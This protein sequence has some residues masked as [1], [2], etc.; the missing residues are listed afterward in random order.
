MKIRFNVTGT[1]RKELVKVISDASG[2]KAKYMGM[3]SAAYEIGDF[4][5]LMD[6]TL[7]IENGED[8][9]GVLDAVLA[10]GFSPEPEETAD[11]AP[12]D[13]EMVNTVQKK[14]QELTVE[15][16]F[17]MVNVGNLMKLLGAKGAL[18][19]KA[20]G[21]ESINIEMKEDRVAFPW[22]F[23]TD[24]DH[25]AAYTRFI[26]ALC[27]MSRESKR[28]TAKEKEV[29]NEKYAFRCLLLRLGFI[30]KDYKS[31]RKILLEKLTGSSA[32]RN[33]GTEHEI[34]E[35]RDSGTN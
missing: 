8:T 17:D 20:L 27:R 29:D 22:F 13:A 24:A 23:G 21:T 30:G 33:G 9:A 3:P 4:R 32:F 26:E 35:W 18:I 12:A 2:V 5:V 25:A 28:I 7:V 15:I 34:S 11:N 10:A 1:K 31:D 16:P 14:D 19:K 6:G